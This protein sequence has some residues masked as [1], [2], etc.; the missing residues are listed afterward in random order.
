MGCDS[1][2]QLCVSVA[3]NRQGGGHR[4]L[5]DLAHNT[6]IQKNKMNLFVPKNITDTMCF[7]ICL[8]NFLNP[9][10]SDQELIRIAKN[11]HTDLALMI[12][13]YII[14][15]LHV[16]YVIRLSV[17]CTLRN[18]SSVRI[19]RDIADLSSVMKCINIRKVTGCA[20]GVTS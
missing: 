20:L 16:T 14:A 8:A 9:H 10:C 12:V 3:R 6:V 13:V 5:T 7:S 1:A 17:T 15:N 4:K 19:A 2:L 18:G 11:I